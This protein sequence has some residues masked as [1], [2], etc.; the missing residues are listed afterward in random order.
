MAITKPQLITINRTIN[1]YRFLQKTNE[2]LKKEIIISDSVSL[3]WYK[4]SLVKDTLYNLEYQKFEK[5]M[6]IN[7]DLRKELERQRKKKIGI[8]V[9]V[10]VSSALIGLLIGLLLN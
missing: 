2:N 8:G 4:I 5:S 7:E 3:Y 1:E 6:Q 9:G 10:G